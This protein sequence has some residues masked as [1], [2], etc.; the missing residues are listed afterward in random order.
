MLYIYYFALKIWYFER[1][2]LFFNDLYIYIYFEE[3]DKWLIFY[4]NC[5]TK[6][7]NY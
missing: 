4:L 2:M 7:L 3:L 6:S 1:I 5:F